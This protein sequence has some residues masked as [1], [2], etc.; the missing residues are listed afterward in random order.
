MPRVCRRKLRS[1]TIDSSRLLLVSAE[2][3]DPGINLSHNPMASELVDKEA[4]FV[5]CL[6]EVY[7]KSFLHYFWFTLHPLAPAL[8]LTNLPLLNPCCSGQSIPCFSA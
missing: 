2:A 5:E 4:H 7:D 3:L 1:G 8:Q 6:G